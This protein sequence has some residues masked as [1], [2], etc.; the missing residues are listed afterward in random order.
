[1]SRTS[2]I[3][4]A[5]RALDAAEHH[6][7]PDRARAADDL[8][9]ILASGPSAPTAA[10]S[11]APTPRRTGRRLAL[12]TGVLATATAAVVVLPSLSGGDQ[13]F[14]S[15]TAL[16]EASSGEQARKAADGCRRTQE[17]GPGA[18]HA[19]E[20]GAAR[21]VIAERRGAWTTVVLAGSEG[22]SALCI[23]DGSSPFFARDWF[24]AIGTPTGYA[25]PEP[26]ELVATSLGVGAIG[27]GELSVAVGTAGTEV[28]SVTYRSARHGA[29][30]AT[31]SDGHFALWLP[32]DEF[33]SS[34][35]PGVEVEVGL[36]DG[37]TT[38]VRLT[39]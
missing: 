7:R 10:A 25:A 6:L 12:A 39:L 33:A 23:T 17:D 2:D 21:A 20:L 4:T 29:V 22:F 30:T 16:P 35:T 18:T 8:E 38:Q 34:S 14:A 32:G 13:A 15:W 1:M 27:A 19:G 28:R 26:R 37:T 9:R 11:G 24:G 3:E 36:A 5:L 31:L